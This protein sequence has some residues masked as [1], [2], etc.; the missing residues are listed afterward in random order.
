MYK[1]YDIKNHKN[2]KLL[3]YYLNVLNYLYCLSTLVLGLNK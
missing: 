1:Y 3:K 2:N